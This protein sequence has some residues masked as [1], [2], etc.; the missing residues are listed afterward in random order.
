MALVVH[1]HLAAAVALDL[2]NH[3]G[4]A[5]NGSSRASVGTGSGSV[6]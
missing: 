5:A 6:P 2:R 4:K 1:H 3:D